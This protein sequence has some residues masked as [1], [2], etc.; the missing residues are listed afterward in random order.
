MRDLGRVLEAWAGLVGRG[1]G[2]VL[3]SVVRVT[4]SAYRR[5]GARMLLPD[6][7]PAVGLVSGGCL[8]SDLA[9]RARALQPGGRPQTPVYDMR[10]PDDIVWGLGLGCDG[11][12]RVLLE[13]LDPAAPPAWLDAVRRFHE[14]ARGVLVTV[15]DAAD[16][17][18]GHVGERLTLSASGECESWIGDERLAAALRG[19]ARAALEQG[20]TR[21]VRLEPFAVEALVEVVEPA[22]RLLVCG[23]G[24]DARPVVE[25]AAGIGWHVR[26]IDH[27]PG[28]IVAERFPG[29]REVALFD[30]ERPGEAGLDVDDRTAVVI[31]THHFL[32]DLALLDR[33]L[34]GPAPYVGLLG[35]ARRRERLLAELAARGRRFAPRRLDRLH[36]PAGLDIGSET[37]EEIALALIAEIRTVLSRRAGGFLRECD[38]PLHGDGP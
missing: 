24:H 13:R 19:E 37:P 20:R 23:A 29:A 6:D 14:R 18:S 1:G 34:D 28:Y 7:A 17:G 9:E 10:S 32:K 33:L 11:E 25:L 38:G 15:F 35:P 30:P 4:G 36:G 12:I 27:R 2:A 31:M 16:D 22:T 5:P 8:E 21:V 26:V 3:A